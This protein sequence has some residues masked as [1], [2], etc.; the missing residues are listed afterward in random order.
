MS[1]Q[2]VLPTWA[3]SIAWLPDCLDALGRQT[4]SA[5]AI[6][7]L[8]G[9]ADDVEALV[10]QRLS[11]ARVIRRRERGGFAVAASAGLRAAT[12][13]LVALIND[14]AVPDPDWLETLRDGAARHPDAGSFACRI[15]RSD[16]PSVL[17]SAGHGL[18]R[19]GE[20]FALGGGAPDGPP[21]DVERRVFGAPATACAY[22]FELLRDCGAFDEGMGAYLEDVDLSLRAQLMGFPCQYLPGSRVHHRGSASYGDASLRLAARNRWRL[23]ARSMPRDLLRAGAPAVALSA[24]AQGLH[25]PAAL[26]GSIEGLR[27]LREAAADR[28][29]TLGA[30]RIDDE[31]L[32]TLL[33]GSEEDLRTLCA[34]GSGAR[35]LRGT[36]SRVLAAAVDARERGVARPPW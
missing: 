11:G 31:A 4:V 25:R 29:A 9:P 8:D 30:R 32:R 18:T 1:V 33:R 21:W 7:V 34:T 16:D 36:L 15:L 13:G 14:D 28:A 26:S 19:W 20:A 17:D 6:V 23:L 27:G 10:R 22:R 5:Q 35:R 2:V 12:A 24:L 3:G